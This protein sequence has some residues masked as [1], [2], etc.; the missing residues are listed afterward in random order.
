MLQREQL[1]SSGLF[2]TF[3]FLFVLFHL[4]YCLTLDIIVNGTMS[5][6]RSFVDIIQK[7]QFFCSLSFATWT[8]FRFSSS[9]SHQTCLN[10][11]VLRNKCHFIRMVSIWCQSNSENVS[12][13]IR[14]RSIRIQPISN[15]PLKFVWS[16]QIFFTMLVFRK[17][18]KIKMAALRI[19]L[20]FRCFFVVHLMT[21]SINSLLFDSYR[22]HE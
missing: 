21:G 1:T 20:E 12:M 11:A 14:F 5:Y 19:W 18:R 10:G 22:F 16:F 3:N 9:S 13:L 4:A 2:S 17:A 15:S 7:V 8:H 6:L